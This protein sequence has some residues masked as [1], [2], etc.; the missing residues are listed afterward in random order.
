LKRFYGSRKDRSTF[1]VEITTGKSGDGSD[2]I[3]LNQ[4]LKSTNE[5]LP[6]MFKF[7]AGG[8]FFSDKQNYFQDAASRT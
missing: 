3:K 8:V 1:P 6:Q 2:H 5:I 4:P 7:G